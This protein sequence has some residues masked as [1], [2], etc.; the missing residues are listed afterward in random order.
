MSLLRMK[1]SEHVPPKRWAEVM[2]NMETWEKWSVENTSV[3]TPIRATVL[4]S[5][6]THIHPFIDGNGR[7]A[8]A[9]T[10]LELVR[11]GYPPIIIKKKEEDRYIEALSESDSGGNLRS[12][13]ELI[14]EKIEGALTGLELSAKK[15]GYSPIQEKIRQ[16][17]EQRLKIWTTSVELLAR[18]VEH[19]IHNEIE[20]MGG[21]VFVKVFE[22]PLDLDDYIS[23]C[24]RRS[25]PKSWAFITYIEIPGIPKQVRLAWIGY[26]SPLMFH[27]LGD[28]GGPSIYWSKKNPEG[29]PKWLSTEIDAPFGV[30]ITTKQGSGDEWYARRSDGRIETMN[31]TVLAKEISRNLIEMAADNK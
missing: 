26:R 14:L 1:G 30:E 4:H 9:I 16:S 28:E 22:S 21:N 11:G 25:A 18:M 5:W 19:F 15:Q 7:C 3:P 27:R 24:D 23:L 31:T 12:F 29:Y 20:P 17:Q 13:F 10:N 6:L 2:N 8:R